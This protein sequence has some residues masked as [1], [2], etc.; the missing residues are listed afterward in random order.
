MCHRLNHIFYYISFITLYIISY[1]IL[2]IILYIIL[3]VILYYIVYHIIWYNIILYCT[4]ILYYIILYHIILY[5][6]ALYYIISYYIM[7]YDIILYC[8]L[9]Y[10]NII[11]YYIVY[12]II[13]YYEFIKWYW[14]R[15]ALWDLASRSRYVLLHQDYTSSPS[16]GRR[17]TAT[18]RAVSPPSELKASFT[19]SPTDGPFR[20]S[21]GRVFWDENP[22]KSKKTRRFWG[23]LPPGL[24]LAS[25]FA[26]NMN[27][28]VQDTGIF[29]Q[30]IIIYI[31]EYIMYT[32]PFSQFY[33]SENRVHSIAI[34]WFI[35]IFPFR[36]PARTWVNL[37]GAK[38]T[39]F[40]PS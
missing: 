38:A 36:R 26:N 15:T 1:I 12:Y 4:Y 40:C 2:H 13:L 28:W 30:S 3:N 20:R 32:L 37:P 9:Y 35:I 27:Y 22:E 24:R 6:I 14:K 16:S 31:T 5:Y 29:M 17:S 25:R 21:F 11:L 18:R 10:I 8:I 19:T 23:Q 7:L 39:R 33:E 34:R